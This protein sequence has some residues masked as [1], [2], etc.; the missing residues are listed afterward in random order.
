MIGLINTFDLLGN[1]NPDIIMEEASKLSLELYEEVRKDMKNSF[2][3]IEEIAKTLLEK[4]TISE[5]ELNKIIKKYRPDI[6]AEEE[7]TIDTKQL[8][9]D[10]VSEVVEE[11]I[12]NEEMDN[13]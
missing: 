9:T 8:V 7:L 11:T 1:Q 2:P 3:C 4:E 10:A 12:N 6:V 13:I 5:S